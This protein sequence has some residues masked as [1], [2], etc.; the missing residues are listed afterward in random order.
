MKTNAIAIGYAAKAAHAYSI[1]LGPIQAFSQ[2]PCY[3]VAE[4]TQEHEFVLAVGNSVSRT[5]MTHQEFKAVR[6]VLY[7]VLSPEF[8]ESMR[9]EAL[10]A[11]R[12]YDDRDE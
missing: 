5:T 2:S 4:T 11:P 3:A 7:R 1:A 9:Q 8:L 6:D 12:P 10:D